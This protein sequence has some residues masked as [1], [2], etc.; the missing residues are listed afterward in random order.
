MTSKNM[1]KSELFMRNNVA[2]IGK[3]GIPLIKKV[4]PFTGEIKLVACSDTKLNDREENIHKGVHFFVDDYRFNGI[5]DNPARTL[6]RYSQ[7]DFLLSPD[8]SLYADMPIWKQI[9][10]TAKNRWVGAY[11]QSKGLKVVPTVSWSN[12]LSFSFCFDGIEEGSVIAIGM[13]GCKKNKV[14][15]IRGYNAMLNKIHPSQIIVFGK[16]FPEMEGNIIV[17]DYNES[18]KVVRDNGR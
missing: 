4:E 8:Y 13:I 11:W 18:R 12:A 5:Y 17:V 9:E 7:Y 1:R 3:Y 14:N 10:N 16:P 15:F 2:T 6:Q